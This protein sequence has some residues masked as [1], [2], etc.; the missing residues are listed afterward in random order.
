MSAKRC[1]SGRV[2]P[3]VAVRDPDVVL[4]VRVGR[5]VVADVE[6][7][8]RRYPDLEELIESCV[9]AD[10]VEKTFGDDQ[11]LEDSFEREY[12]AGRSRCVR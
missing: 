2:E 11:N 8:S 10:D 5:V 12:R 7:D 4:A 6:G 9:A 3:K 1:T